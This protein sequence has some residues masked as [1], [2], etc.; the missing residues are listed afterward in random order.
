MSAFG[1]KADVALTPQ[2]SALPAWII[3]PRRK[4]AN[5]TANISG[6]GA[7]QYGEISRGTMAWRD[8]CATW[9]TNMKTCLTPA[10]STCLISAVLLGALC[11][12]LPTVSSATTYTYT[13][14]SATDIVPSFS[15]TTSLT[16]AALDNLAPNTDITGTV[17]AFTFEPR[18]VPPEDNFGFALGGPFGSS[19]FNV[20]SG[21]TVLI[22]TN[23][24]GQITAWNISEVIFASYP[25]V[26]GE[27][28]GDFFC[29]YSA[30]TATGGGSLS[31]TQ[32]HD[33]G[34]CGAGKTSAVGTFAGDSGVA[35]A[36]PLPAALPLFATGLGALGLLG[37]RR[38]KK[39]AALAA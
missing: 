3:I 34:L 21:P 20:S 22:G 9:G 36:T 31:L 18:G 32:D 35:A 1:G 6:E 5:G 10:R 19:Y 27:I 8:V 37:W 25:A 29:T 26:P 4:F 30:G 14:G 24:L 28:P 23:A 38:K 12:L 39:A 16:G 15:F 17:S 13:E 2:W 11:A 7:R 33:A